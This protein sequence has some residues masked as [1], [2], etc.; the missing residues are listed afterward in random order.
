[1]TITGIFNLELS[2]ETKKANAML[3]GLGSSR[4]V[5]LS[6]TLLE[7][8][9]DDRSPWSLPR[10]GHHIRGHI[11]KA[12]AWR[13]WLPPA[14]GPVALATE[15]LRRPGR[16]PV[17]GGGGWAG[18]VELHSHRVPLIIGPA[19]NAISRH[20]ERQADADA[21]RLTDNPAAFRRAFER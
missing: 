19:T 8:F 21:L 20:F 4:R 15:S 18:P 14:G 3:A 13:R 11:V 10:T 7:A 17:D 9:S 2:K 16:R 1:M 5:Y 12:L 6:D